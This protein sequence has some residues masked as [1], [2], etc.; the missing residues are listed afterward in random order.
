MV[1]LKMN[2]IRR[3]KKKKKEMEDVNNLVLKMART[4]K[5]VLRTMMDNKMFGRQAFHFYN[6]PVSNG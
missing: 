1:S 4:E 6:D 2:L 3:A 5:N